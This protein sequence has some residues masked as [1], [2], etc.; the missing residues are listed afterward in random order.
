M[1]FIKWTLRWQYT[2]TF[3]RKPASEIYVPKQRR[4]LT[5]EEQLS[6]VDSTGSALNDNSE[7]QDNAVARKGRGKF[8]GPGNDNQQDQQQQA[9]RT[10]RGR[11]FDATSLRQYPPKA[12]DKPPTKGHARKKSKSDSRRNSNGLQGSE[13]GSDNNASEEVTK[14]AN[15]LENININDNN[16]NNEDEAGTQNNDTPSTQQERLVQQNVDDWESHAD[17]AEVKN[18][19]PIASPVENPFDWQANKQKAEMQKNENAK[20]DNS[21]NNNNNNNNRTGFKKGHKK[22]KSSKIE[23]NF[24]PGLSNLFFFFYNLFIKRS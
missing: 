10:P 20:I 12:G 24:D 5:D 21:N 13:S 9:S 16:N 3:L 4:S 22:S 14:I 15:S 2:F 19:S 11:D 18:K 17:A 23:F 6:L 7:N 1:P 8:Y